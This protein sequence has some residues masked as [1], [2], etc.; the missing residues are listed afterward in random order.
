MPLSGEASSVSQ[1]GTYFQSGKCAGRLFS[2]ATVDH[3]EWH[4][5]PNLFQE[6]MDR[7]GLPAMDIFASQDNTQLPRF[8]TRFAILE[9]EGINVLHSPWPQGLLYTILPL[10][11]IPKVIWKVLVEKAKVLLLALYWPSQPWFADLVNQWPEL[12]GYSQTESPSA[13]GPWSTWNHSGSI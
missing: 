4:L 6:L 5:D 3:S 13:K 10:P 2:R 9:A 1:G 12:G 8:F 7:F 11:L